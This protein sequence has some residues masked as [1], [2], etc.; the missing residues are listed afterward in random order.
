[1]ENSLINPYI[2]KIKEFPGI[3]F[4]G[5]DCLKAVKSVSGPIRLDIGCGNGEALIFEAKQNRDA[6]YIGVE[7]QYKEVYRTA[8]KIKS[9]DLSNC[10]VLQL[11]AKKIPSLFAP[12]QIE[13]VNL[14]FPDPW[15]KT[16][17]KKNRLIHPTYLKELFPKMKKGSC[18]NIRTDNDDYFMHILSVVYSLK[19]EFNLDV[20]SFSRDYYRYGVRK[21]SCITAF[22]RIFLKQG[23]LINALS[24]NVGKPL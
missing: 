15:P 20:T 6:N 10:L 18:F 21:D 16:K 12:D 13:Q 3:V 11:D 1:M 22:E 9:N 14:F 19:D 23:L 7:L 24:F 8:S 4:S 17:Q 2:D 5:A